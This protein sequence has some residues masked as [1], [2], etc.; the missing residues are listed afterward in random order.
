MI[1]YW[2][3]VG[4]RNLFGLELLNSRVGSTGCTF[5]LGDNVPPGQG[6]F[7]KIVEHVDCHLPIDTGY[8]Q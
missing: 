3:S 5:P 8:H 1:E 7:V 2:N 6:S 4:Q